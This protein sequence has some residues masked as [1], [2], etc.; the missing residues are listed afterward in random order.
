[1]IDGFVAIG[2]LTAVALLLVVFRS[3]A[4]NGPAS[5]QALFPEREPKPP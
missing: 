2:F 5:P 1:V 4:P 3:T